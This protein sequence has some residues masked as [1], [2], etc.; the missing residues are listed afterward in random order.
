MDHLRVTLLDLLREFDKRSL[1]LTVGG[2]YGLFLKREHLIRTGER[3]LFLDALPE[4]RST[5]DIDL[6]SRTEVIADKESWGGVA[7]AIAALS[8]EPIPS[9]L[10]SQWARRVVINGV[11]QAMKIDLLVGPLDLVKDEVKA[12]DRRARPKKFKGNLHAH[13]TP[14]ALRIDEQPISVTVAGTTSDGT[15]HSGVVFI[16]EA[17]SYLL[18]KLHAYRD[19]KN[20]ENKDLGRHHALD[21]YSVVGMM[22]EEEY[23]RAKQFGQKD[24]DSEPV[25]EARRIVAE[26]FASGTATGMIRVKEH[27]LFRPEFKTGE[28]IEVLKEI[29]PA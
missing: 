15:S 4:A 24:R 2:G 12:D 23:E 26:D 8:C 18:M 21:A 17:F 11:E 29:F 19:Q 6:F 1:P 16:P 28:F 9:A 5:N 22:T 20:K 14:E 27:P 25:G 13:P 3:T 10:Y 7:E